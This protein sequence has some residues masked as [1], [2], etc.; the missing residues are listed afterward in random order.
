MNLRAFTEKGVRRFEDYILE[1]RKGSQGALPEDLLDGPDTFPIDD[2]IL[3]EPGALPLDKYE[4]AKY[5][6][7]L[8][9]PVSSTKLKEH[10]RGIWT[11]LAAFYFERIR[12]AKANSPPSAP[13]HY[14]YEKRWD[15]RYRHLLA[16]PHEL[17]SLYGTGRGRREE[18]VRLFLNG[19]V[20]VLGGIIEQLASRQ[21]IITSR[22]VVQALTELYWDPIRQA[23]KTG[24]TTDDR[25]RSKRSKKRRKGAPRRQSKSQFPGAGGIVRFVKVFWQLH[26]TYDLYS[27]DASQILELLPREFDGYRHH[28]IAK[29]G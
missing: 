4:A 3:V 9:R 23:P 7:D 1:L 5:L 15:R 26:L 12:P 16:F 19:S 2:S 18:D 6:H 28:P 24:I 27:L 25:D 10:S 13:Y 14:I 22:P 11:W 21:E 20:R 29:A 8:L 17:Y